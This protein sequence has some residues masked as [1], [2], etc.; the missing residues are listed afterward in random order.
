[1]KT[2]L[3]W[4][5]AANDARRGLLTV[6]K[7]RRVLNEMLSTSGQAIDQESTEDFAARWLAGK[8]KLK[9]S[10][11]VVRYRPIINRFLA[12]LGQK[13]KMP[14]SS[15]TPADIERYRDTIIAAGKS[16]HSVRLE[17]KTLS[18]LLTHALK[19]GM[20]ANNPVSAVEL[21][22]STTHTKEPFTAEEVAQLLTATQGTPWHGAI[23]T[24]A[25]TGLRLGDIAHLRWSSIDL[26]SPG[27]ET[28]TVKPAKTQRKG[29][30]LVIPLHGALV[31]CLTEMA[32]DDDP[33]GLLFPTLAIP[34][35]GWNGL[36]SQFARIMDSAGIDRQ[37][38][39]ATGAGRRVSNKS[40]HSLRHYAVSE[41]L[42][43]GV[44]E[45]LRMKLVGHSTP[46]MNKR[47]SH[48][49]TASLRG[50]IQKLAAPK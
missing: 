13:A 12:S 36:S 21:D 48:A 1:M 29:R 28:L 26:A 32:S 5:R 33:D 23:L 40:F 27:S 45:A 24:A 14:L 6:E 46:A 44:D 43:A 25:L 49:T 39:K 41:L 31:A 20:I 17:M 47:Y 8:G 15:I 7:A 4:E 35:G 42:N 34:T 2:A 10:S 50:A 11:T 18:A 3:D 30:T 38:T 19:Q 16:P 22:D 37:K 9:A